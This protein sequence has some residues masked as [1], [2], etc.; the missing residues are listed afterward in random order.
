MFI[1]GFLWSSS[2]TWPSHCLF[3]C[4]L[5][6]C[7]S[8]N[9]SFLY[10]RC[11]VFSTVQSVCLSH[12]LHSPFIDH[13]LHPPTISVWVFSLLFCLLTWIAN[14]LSHSY[15]FHS[16]YM[17]SHIRPFCFN[18]LFWDSAGSTVT[19]YRLDGL[20]IKSWWWQDILHLSGLAHSPIQW[21]SGLSQ[22]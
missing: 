8:K 11:P 15:F 21:I 19:C 6:L 5:A 12:T 4:L 17:P 18:I 14:S 9:L 1:R 22:G 2:W 20:R 10:S 3:V 16:D 7:S 13:S